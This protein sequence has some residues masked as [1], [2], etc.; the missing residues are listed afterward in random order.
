MSLAILHRSVK[1]ISF[2]TGSGLI[3]PG[4]TVRR[5]FHEVRKCVHAG[6]FYT[7][8]EVARAGCASGEKLILSLGDLNRSCAFLIII[9][10]VIEPRAHRVGP[11]QP[12]IIRPVCV[13]ALWSFGSE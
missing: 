5:V 13:A 7:I 2:D 11:H 6:E 4:N 1:H 10:H 3:R 9:S 12:S 8:A